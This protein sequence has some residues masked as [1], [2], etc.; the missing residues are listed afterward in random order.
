MGRDDAKAVRGLQGGRAPALAFSSFMREAV[1]GRPVEEFDT[2]VQLPGWMLEPDEE[3][4]Y[5]DPDDYYFIDEDGNLVDPQRREVD[6]YGYPLPVEGEQVPGSGE[7]PQL[8]LPPNEAGQAASDDFLDRAT[9]ENLPPP[10]PPR[11]PRTIRSS[12]T[13]RESVN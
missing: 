6:R 9:G 7:R 2:E 3:Y 11:M 12:E 5:G 4:L 8:T 10:A 13:S 1:K